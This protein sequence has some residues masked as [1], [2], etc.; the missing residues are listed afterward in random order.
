M[1]ANPRCDRCSAALVWIGIG[2]GAEPFC[3]RDCAPIDPG[4]RCPKCK[5]LKI[6]P[7][8]VVGYFIVLP[9]THC[10]DCGNV[11]WKKDA[12]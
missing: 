9:D 12:L 10:V 7:Y 1:N 6:E 8:S 4:T 5:S 2:P 11:F 3:P